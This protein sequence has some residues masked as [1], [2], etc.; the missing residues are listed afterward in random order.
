MNS[1]AYNQR[2][3]STNTENQFVL[4]FKI[5]GLAFFCLMSLSQAI[6]VNKTLAADDMQMSAT[7]FDPTQI[8]VEPQGWWSPTCNHIHATVRFPVKQEVSGMLNLDVRAV[9][10]KNSCQFQAILFEDENGYV[11]KEVPMTDKFGRSLTCTEP[12]NDAC[13]VNFPVSLDTK[14]F[15]GKWELD[16]EGNMTPLNGGDGWHTL[17]IR[18]TS[19][20]GQFIH[21]EYFST[22]S[23]IP[24]FTK[25]GLP[26]TG[27]E[28]SDQ[29]RDWVRGGGWHHESQGYAIAVIKDFPTRPISGSHTFW[30]KSDSPTKHC[31]VTLDRTHYI[32]ATDDGK[33]PEVPVSAG[34][35]LFDEE[36]DCRE[37]IPV[38]VDTTTLTNGW[39]SLGVQVENPNL[40][41]DQGF[42]E[43]G[44]NKL[45]GVMKFWFFVDNPAPG[46]ATLTIAASPTVITKGQGS[47][48]SINA[49]NVTGCTLSGGLNETLPASAGSVVA[50]R[51]V[52]PPRST[53]YM[54]NCRGTDGAQVVKQASIGVLPKPITS[55][56]FWTGN[57]RTIVEYAYDNNRIAW[58]EDN[59]PDFFPLKIM[60]ITTG[61]QR[62]LVNLERPYN[63]QITFKGDYI[64]Y[65]DGRP[66]ASSYEDPDLFVFDLK[67]N[68]EIAVSTDPGAN[69]FSAAI[70]GDHLVF[71][72]DGGVGASQLMYYNIATGE[73]KTL[74][75]GFPD[76]Y[77]DKTSTPSIYGDYVVYLEYH[78]NNGAPLTKVG[79]SDIFLYDLAA[80]K[81]VQITND[82]SMNQYS[83]IIYENRIIWEDSINFTCKYPNNNPY[84]IDPEKVPDRCASAGNDLH[85]CEYDSI[86]QACGPIKRITPSMRSTKYGS[87]YRSYP[88][89]SGDWL[90]FA[91]RFGG[92][93][94]YDPR[95]YN[96]KTGDWVVMNSDPNIT[97]THKLFGNTTVFDITP[98]NETKQL[99]LAELP[100]V[101]LSNPNEPT[102]TI[103][104]PQEGGKVQGTT[105]EVTYTLSGDISVIDHVHLKLD[106]L[107]E[108]RDP[109]KDGRHTFSGLGIGSHTIYA[110]G[111]DTSHS[112]IPSTEY[113]VHF[114]VE[115]G[116]GQ[117]TLKITN[118][119]EGQNMIDSNVEVTYTLS[120]DISVIDHVHLKLDNLPEV[121]DPEKDGRYTFSGLGIGS[122]T[123]YAY[124]A[125]T[126]HT[127]IP[128]TEHTVHF[129]VVKPSPGK[130]IR[131]IMN[132]AAQDFS[133]GVSPP[134]Q[135]IN[136]GQ[137]TTYTVSV[138]A[139]GF[140]SI[141]NFLATGFAAGTSGTFNPVSCA[142]PCST[143]L[144]VTSTNA[145]Q[146]GSRAIT[147]TGT[148]G[149]LTKTAQ[150][151]LTIKTPS[152]YKPYILLFEAYKYSGT[153]P[154]VQ[155]EYI[156]A[157]DAADT[158]S[159][160]GSSSPTDIQW[161]GPKP[162]GQAPYAYQ[163]FT[164]PNS[165]TTYTLTC[166]NAVGSDARSIVIPPL[167]TI[168]PF[169]SQGPVV[170]NFGAT[171]GV[172]FNWAAEDN[173][174]FDRGLKQVRLMRAKDDGVRCVDKNNDGVL[175]DR[176]LCGLGVVT[177][178]TKNFSTIDTNGL[179][180]PGSS[181]STSD[182][183]LSDNGQLPAGTYYYGLEAEDRAGQVGY[184]PNP[185]KVVKGG[186]PVDSLQIQIVH[187]GQ[188][189]T[190]T[191]LS[192]VAIEASVS[193]TATVSKVEFYNGGAKLGEDISSPY[194][195]LWE[196]V[197]AG[198]YTLTAK[199][200][201]SGGLIKISSPVTITLIDSNGNIPP[202]VNIT[203]PPDGT[204]YNLVPA[205][206]NITAS[207]TDSDGTINN[208]GFFNGSVKLGED[209]SAPYSFSWTNVA[210]GTYTLTARATD[211]DG[212]TT[213]SN[214]VT[215]TVK[216]SDISDNLNLSVAIGPT[217]PGGLVDQGSVQEYSFVVTNN[218]TADA[219]NVTVALEVDN[220][221]IWPGWGEVKSKAINVPAG[222]SASGSLSWGPSIGC[223]YDARIVV[224]KG[225]QAKDIYASAGYATRF[226]ACVYRTD[227]RVKSV[228]WPNGAVNVNQTI[229]F[230][231]T[232]EN[233]G[234][235]ETAYDIKVELYARILG[236][237][238]PQNPSAGIKFPGIS[239][240][241]RGPVSSSTCFADNEAPSSNYS[242]LLKWTPDSPGEYE[243][244][245]KAYDGNEGEYI[246]QD[247]ETSGS[248]LV[249]DSSI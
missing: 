69:E 87:Y 159:C 155:E 150:A 191:A 45:E 153:N 112:K 16:T 23:Q 220:T 142:A 42:P 205:G 222:K 219:S 38:T 2:R 43:N 190:Y 55:K 86:A 124:G 221:D 249:Q 62:T 132:V 162:V 170:V 48:L 33:W 105:L 197:P 215:V 156:M 100:D 20:Y 17:S 74:V 194:T 67:N 13:A 111:A 26:P 1:K 139:G 157:W 188:G 152:G 129:Q 169:D 58:I 223:F 187:P 174:K 54:V 227:I 201:A 60:D 35:L 119:Q 59:G 186:P 24:L 179:Y 214:G 92:T 83:P 65:G 237:V 216:S 117:P 241:G 122:H 166:T 22:V 138:N 239:R 136:A 66:N 50:S 199:A 29:A 177:G 73:K 178:G 149:G 158:N 30:F 79:N 182:G 225:N 3:V 4:S 160:T 95:A 15:G 61:T 64:A 242:D 168:P 232:L 5:I 141:M 103:T 224:R 172:D 135:S 210:A 154:P 88:N 180:G 171:N 131:V 99:F 31:K 218:G 195:F 185:I 116:N 75:P 96:L 130:P 196:I 134:S 51:S 97:Y 236:D 163:G 36:T 108:V 120:G 101:A 125:D 193:G 39:H 212:S 8:P 240:S 127:K 161:N 235:S 208:V 175:D 202:T 167:P 246:G 164:A 137:S 21:Q 102:L 46:A 228:V 176:I 203:S 89:L 206:I 71:V 82:N 209:T 204:V 41:V 109:E 128:S 115:Q 91:E 27:R 49:N 28:I 181:S 93:F 230:P 173:R 143:T 90:T 118:P 151:T 25:N 7:A 165:R 247:N 57:S 80:D 106:N 248:V 47:T 76:G 183:V 81:K 32:P 123:I 18:A 147:I 85:S 126:S 12:V 14:L 238:W 110:Y 98:P 94:N 233:L 78:S 37:F 133:L 207:A 44:L 189:D 40:A 72:F 140:N 114:Q 146:P 10:H 107:P 231:L 77:I 70:Y 213:T 226:G 52:T 144:N 63:Y 234:C 19:L 217:W 229:A 11:I 243:V 34:A 104:S 198:T 84:L 192:S 68:R 145:A 9:M 244:M 53:E 148:G 113:T 121:K 245:I 6:F 200:F 56:Q 184:I 211:N